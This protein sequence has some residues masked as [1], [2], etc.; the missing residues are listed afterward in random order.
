MFFSI[1]GR[2]HAQ[3]IS[4]Q[5]TDF[6]VSFGNNSNYPHGDIELQIRVVASDAATVTFTYTESGTTN[7]VSIASGGVYTYA[8]TNQE[9][10]EIYS[11][12]QGI[13]N[14]SLHIQSDVPVSVYALNQYSAT[15]DA[16]NVLP[17]AGLGTDY[18]HI[19]YKSPKP[20]GENARS[21]G[22]T[23]I[24]TENNTEIYE[25]NS[26]K[27]ILQKGQ[28]YSGYFDNI[29]VTGKHITS[30][31]PIAYF[32]T[33]SGVNIPLNI[34]YLDCL[35]E[36][37]VP[38]NRWGN[39]FLV[40]VTHRGVE[41]IRIVASQDGTVVTQTGGVITT[42]DGGFSQ[43][44][45]NLNKG[46][47]VEMEANLDSCGC[48]ITSNRPVGVCTYLTGT[49][50][51]LSL[52]TGDPS[53]AWVPPIEQSINSAL[54]AP[55][56]PNGTTLLD[57]HY[58]LIVTQTTTKDQ[59]T[60]A[61]GTD[62]ATSLTGGIWC[63]NI[64]SNFSFY[65]L[66]LNN[67]NDAYYFANPHGLTVMA[68]GIG[69][70]ESYYYLAASALRNLDAEF[71]VNNIHYLDFDGSIICDT[72]V[73]YRATMQNAISAT[74]GY[75]KWYIDGIEQ[76]A[77]RDTLE[78]SGTLSIGSHNVYIEVLNMEDTITLSTSFEIIPPYYD[79]IIAEICLGD[80]YK[81]DNF[82]TIPLQA[83]Y[84][85]CSESKGCD[86]IFTLQLTINPVY[87]DTINAEICL[88]DTY[89]E[90]G[91]DVTTA[92]T[93]FISQTKYLKSK[94]G[95]DSIVTL[96]LTTNAVYNYT[97]SEAICLGETYS[98]AIFGNIMPTQ[99]GTEYY[100]RE[101]KT[102]LYYCD[103]IINLQLTVNPSYT[104]FIKDTI[105]EDEWSYVG[106]CKYNTPGIHVTDYKTLF[107]CDSAIYLDLYVMYYPPEITAFSPFNKDG[108]NDY[109][110]PG[111]K[112]QIFNR[113]GALIYETST[114]EEQ[115][116]G[117]DG[118]NSRKQ[119]VEP[120][121]YFYIL[122]NSSGKPRIKSSI[123]VLKK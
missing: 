96:Q 95:C 46:E 120:G 81:D 103:S 62:S 59:T 122:Y 119:D 10:D 44:S 18:Y 86:S 84:I 89:N 73:N 32:V 52:D 66:P 29:D 4:T 61:T 106:N 110:M 109:F 79:T 15:T 93:G 80:R 47:F 104:T 82:D 36:Q 123:E 28:V 50:Y 9:K 98:D 67:P 54:I 113:H 88:G 75:L 27:A 114:V 33:N 2:L 16:T 12:N 116:S 76:I 100:S 99:I 21:D 108:V 97:I 68:Y 111:F 74:H 101:L 71:Y 30:N 70:A 22:Y 11:L 34:S 39:N 14:K 8:F 87:Y 53:V 77:V 69:D 38:V 48:Y 94:K 90:N 64:S 57:R 41:R 31:H 91:F 55:F 40:P 25:D 60:M 6:W 43:G 102:N 121:L 3:T 115:E 7:T 85:E 107:G 49:F 23:V 45:L 20:V 78:W 56:V 65:S 35:F 1:N 24:A 17:I 37:L 92:A 72:V 117:W 13:S 58:A 5:G 118:R 42:D 83:G 19:S 112:V 51:Q 63:D 105:Y 26:Q